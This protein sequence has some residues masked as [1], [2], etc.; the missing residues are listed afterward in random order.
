MLPTTLRP[1]RWEVLAMT[2]GVVKG[3]LA[4]RPAKTDKLCLDYPADQDPSGCHV[5]GMATIG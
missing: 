3:E 2:E 4:L 1:F 5:G